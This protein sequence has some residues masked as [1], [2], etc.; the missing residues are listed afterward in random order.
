MVNYHHLYTNFWYL[1]SCSK[2]RNSNLKWT[3]HSSNGCGTAYVQL[4]RH[5]QFLWVLFGVLNS[6]FSNFLYYN[7]FTHVISKT[8]MCVIVKHVLWCSVF[9]MK[10]WFCLISAYFSQFNRQCFKVSTEPQH[11]KKFFSNVSSVSASYLFFLLMIFILM[12]YLPNFLFN[13]FCEIHK[14]VML[15]LLV[16]IFPIFLDPVSLLSYLNYF[17]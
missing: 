10:L 12:C 13:C 5:C 14:S 2:F 15:A 9:C 8:L 4:P 1:I 3:L 17:F 11:G 7:L 6:S 16:I